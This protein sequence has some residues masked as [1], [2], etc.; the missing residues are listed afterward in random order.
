MSTQI[1]RRAM[2]R[3]MALAA[4]AGMLAACQPAPTATPTKASSVV[5]QPTKPAP[6]AA[7]AQPVKLSQLTWTIN[8]LIMPKLADAMKEQSGGKIIVE[9]TAVGWSDYWNK[10]STLFAAGSPPDAAWNHTA[11]VR[12]HAKLG[13]L[14]D[15]KPYPSFPKDFYNSC[16]VQYTYRNGQWGVPYDLAVRSIH[17]NQTLFE[18]AGLT[19]VPGEGWT[20]DDLR[21]WATRIT[22]DRAGKHPND[23]GFDPRA[24]L[25]W[26]MTG[27]KS[28]WSNQM[29][30]IIISFGGDLFNADSTECTI[31]SAKAMEAL[32]W[33]CDAVNTWHICSRPEIETELGNIYVAGNAG[34]A[35][36]FNDIVYE[37]VKE[38]PKFKWGAAVFPKAPG[39][40]HT[41]NV[42]SSCHSIPAK[43]AHPDEAWIWLQFLV[44]D[45]SVVVWAQNGTIPSRKIGANTVVEAYNVSANWR[46][47]CIDSADTYGVPVW[48]HEKRAQIEKA[49]DDE[50]QLVWMGKRDLEEA[51][52]AAKGKVD[53]LLK[54]A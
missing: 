33:L 40:R 44:N 41:V 21:D 16:W 18:K 9:I 49:I 3:D 25:Q 42:G 28:G 17:Y 13:A 30:P 23:A 51:A 12:T 53:A 43:A 5:S 39:G 32:K 27:M 11:Y 36:A 6:T 45:Q 22:T 46:E 29:R 14:K 34:V 48:Q 2:L 26:G 20:W 54:Q 24:V 50:F 37:F 19:R 4:S 31:T 38:P 52:K 15:L 7:P 10:L 1:T 47:A 35:A 8:D